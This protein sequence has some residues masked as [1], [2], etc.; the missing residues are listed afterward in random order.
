MN[1]KKLN[2]ELEKVFKY[3]IDNDLPS[4]EYFLN[5]NMQ[6]PEFE[7]P[8][9]IKFTRLYPRLSNFYMEVHNIPKH[10]FKVQHDYD[11]PDLEL[12]YD[13][14]AT[15]NGYI[16]ISPLCLPT[17]DLKALKELKKKDIDY[18]IS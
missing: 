6:E 5:V 18:A 10:V 17:G 7:K 15:K 11:T 3:I 8:K 13:I 16:S 9:G 12:E 2:E 1:I 4:T 14:T